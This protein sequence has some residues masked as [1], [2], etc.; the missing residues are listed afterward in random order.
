MNA[1]FLSKFRQPPRSE[2]ARALSAK[3]TQTANAGPRHPTAKRIAY[4]LASL[5]L[6]FVL[7]IAISPTA[8]AAALA[9]VADII[10]TLTVK[11]TV[12]IVNDDQ[13]AQSG[14]GE[15]YAEIWKPG[16]PDEIAADYPF[17]AK[18][19]A[20]VPAGFVL[21]ERAA[22]IYASMYQEI[23]SS[24]LVEW[25]NKRG[26][27]IQLHIDEGSCP[28]GVVFDPNGT[29]LELGS[30]CTQAALF[31]VSVENQPETVTVN[32][33][34]AVL[35]HNLQFL[36]DLS[37]PVRPWNPSRGKFDNRDREALYLTWENDGRIFGLAS[38]SRTI[39]K[40]ELLRMAESIP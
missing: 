17:F 7:V 15:T 10:K 39:S 1:D 20:W 30:D 26:D 22:L 19:P 9:A 25:K 36:M 40:Q 29:S 6:I 14:E 31:S 4:A 16:S 32:D 12:V 38:K 34:P 28:N 13:P 2:F 33:Q 24:V 21:Q 3:L 27:I 23:P 37:D 5:C 18:L 35:F 8:R 11:G